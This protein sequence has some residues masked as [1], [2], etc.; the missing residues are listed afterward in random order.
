MHVTG[1]KHRI[2]SH[3]NRMGC[4]DKI[5]NAPLKTPIHR[6]QRLHLLHFKNATLDVAGKIVCVERKTPVIAVP[7]MK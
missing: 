1:Y 4:K 3:G 2:G 6:H 5:R 7:E